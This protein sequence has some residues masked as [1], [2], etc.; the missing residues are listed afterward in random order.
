MLLLDDNDVG[1]FFF[2]AA[3][4]VASQHVGFVAEGGG[5]Q[6]LGRWWQFSALDAARI[7]LGRALVSW[8][9]FRPFR[10]R[11]SVP[12]GVFG[13]FLANQEFGSRTRHRIVLSF[14]RNTMLFFLSYQSL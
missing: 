10:C 4:V 5:G 6:S 3:L 11:L 7:G 13:W 12:L 2:S 1:F 8:F 9:G 14:V